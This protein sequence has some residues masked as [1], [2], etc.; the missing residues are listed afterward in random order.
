MVHSVPRKRPART[1]SWPG[2]DGDAGLAH[3][4]NIRQRSYSTRS[5]DLVARFLPVI[6]AKPER[7]VHEALSYGAGDDFVPALGIVV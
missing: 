2:E 3:L 6:L 4:R 1:G 7:F 5:F